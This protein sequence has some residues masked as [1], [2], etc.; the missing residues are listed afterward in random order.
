MK[1]LFKITFV[2]FAFGYSL[3]IAQQSKITFEHF[4][5][6]DGLPSLT[7]PCLFQDRIGYLWFGTFH[8]IA[9]Y[10]GYLFVS[11]T[12]IEGDSTSIS[13]AYIRAICDDSYG[14]IWIGHSQ[15]LDKFNNSTESFT[16]FILNNKFPLTDWCNHVLSLLEDSDSTLWIGTGRGLYKFNRETESFEW[17]THND[18]DSGSLSSNNINAIYEDKDKKLWF[19]TGKGLNY[20]NKEKNSFVHYLYPAEKYKDYGNV[21]NPYWLLSILEDNVGT[22]WLGSSGGIIEFNRKTNEHVL[23]QHDEKDPESLADNIVLSISEDK[24]GYL[25]I[26]TKEGVDI[27]DK[28]TKVFYHNKHDNKDPQS[29]GSNDV[30]QIITEKSGTIWISLYGAGGVAKYTPPNP[31]IKQYNDNNFLSGN[32]QIIYE[33]EKKTLWVGLQDGLLKF[34]SKKEIFE[35]ILFNKEINH[36]LEDQTGTLWANIWKEGIYK[37]NKNDIANTFLDARKAKFPTSNT[38]ICKSENGNFWIGNTVGDIFQFNPLSDESEIIAHY[39]TW[40]E[41]VF[42]DSKGILWIGT[43]EM[44]IIC[45]N[46]NAKVFNYYSHI[47]NDSLTIS[48][49]NVT[50][51]CEDKNGDIWIIASQTINKFERLKNRFIHNIGKNNFPNDVY[52]I[53]ED[54]N[55]KL[56]FTTLAGAV[57]Y[58]ID[59]NNF[60]TYRNLIGIGYKSKN[61]EILLNDFSSIIRF[62]PDSLRENPFIPPIVITDFRLFEKSHSFGKEIQVPYNENYISFEFAALS[63]INPEKNQYSY[64]MEGVDKDW[65]NSGS[66][67]Y[68]SYPNL[69]PGEYTFR[70][71]GSNNDG[72]WNEAGT[73]VLIIISPP[74]WK[75]WWAYSS[76]ALIFAFT[77]FG[78]RRYEMNRLKLKDKIKLDEAVLKEKEETDKMK[79][80][81][82]ANISHE[83]RTPLTLILGPAEKISSKTS[84]DVVKDA[85]IIKRNS[86]RLLQLIN[87]LLDLS[88]LESGKLKL[89]VSKGNIVSFV[90]GVALSFESLAESKDITLKL[91]PEKEFIEMYFDKEKMMKILTNIL[92]NAFKFTSEEGKIT[93]SIKENK[94]SSV[95]S[96]ESSTEKSLSTNNEIPKQVRDDNVVEIK[97]RDTGIGITQEEI[98]KLFDRFYQVDSSH[99]REYEGTGIGLALT[100]EL[101]ELHHGRIIVESEKEYLLNL[102]CNFLLAEII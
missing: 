89:E 93:V 81:F 65:I 76:Y 9:K 60:T 53:M 55:R 12:P 3:C 77:L 26:S 17:Y 73:S 67:R 50:Q 85:N 52:Y 94:L 16:H 15:G 58:D 49:N 42:E 23:Y 4:G 71:K 78:I 21:D 28:K 66:R 95:I 31:Q 72:V 61:G 56:W 6:K 18:S 8:G 7:V 96:R 36:I 47:A 35:K 25:W 40:I 24:E 91:L 34:N 98:P 22:F 86:R 32:I 1:S 90:K 51:F 79:S 70:V 5:L 29:I 41:A 39:P 2:I 44:G 57:I 48:G 11:Y 64:K 33:D 20:Y 74:W 38:A 54:G 75:T 14:N 87:Q 62:N 45:Y 92:S 63:F 68:A 82:F 37:I 46:I 59:S 83:F 97:I 88:K 102:L 84:D 101:V 100:K 19:A 30:G 27:F 13:N 99:T 10:D 80:S 43:R 69:D